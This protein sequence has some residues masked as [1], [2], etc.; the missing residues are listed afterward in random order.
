MA[1]GHPIFSGLDEDDFRGWRGDFASFSP[2]MNKPFWGNYRSLMDLRLVGKE[3]EKRGSLLLEAFLAGKK[4]IFCQLPVCDTIPEEPVAAILFENLIRY[5][6]L[7]LDETGEAA[8]LSPPGGAIGDFFRKLGLVAR[9]NPVDLTRFDRIVLIYNQESK[10]YISREG[11][12]L[13]TWLEEIL[14]R[15]GTVLILG[16]EPDTIRSLDKILPK[17]LRLDKVIAPVTRGFVKRD[18]PF[19]W[20]I[21]DCEWTECVGETEE[22]FEDKPVYEIVPVSS[23]KGCPLT[24]PPFIYQLRSREGTI[25]ICQWPF[26]RQEKDRESLRILCQFLTNLGFRL[27]KNEKF[28]QGF[29]K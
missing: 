11:V 24:T 16:L 26:F 22:F 21:A 12:N 23:E 3:K 14:R 10:E 28:L 5:S 25:I 15:G 7:P 8:L 4:M 2:P 1:P 29:E 17:G 27:K 6:L 18:S 20:G 9:S 19:F 13:P